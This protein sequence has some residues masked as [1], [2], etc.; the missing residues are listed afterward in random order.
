MHPVCL[1]TGCTYF[2]APG[3]Q[4][5]FT[6]HCP[7]PTAHGS[8]HTAH[9]TLHLAH[10]ILHTAH[11][12]QHTLDFAVLWETWLEEKSKANQKNCLGKTVLKMWSQ[13]CGKKPSCPQNYFEKKVQKLKTTKT[14]NHK[15]V[16]NLWRLIRTNLV[17]FVNFWD[18]ILKQFSLKNVLF[19]ILDFNMSRNMCKLRHKCVLAKIYPLKIKF[20]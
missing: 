1:L 11:F 17:L 2:L 13:I 16:H 19:P 18:H 15:C 3:S 9:W 5:H 10:C 6:A 12:T 4:H 8:L 14:K 7:L 20:S